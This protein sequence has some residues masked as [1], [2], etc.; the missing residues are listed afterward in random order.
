MCL[1]FGV[2]LV[3]HQLATNENSSGGFLSKAI[4]ELSQLFQP[5][6]TRLSQT[7]TNALRECHTVEMWRRLNKGQL[8]ISLT[9]VEYF[10]RPMR[11]AISANSRKENPFDL[12]HEGVL[13]L[14]NYKTFPNPLTR[15]ERDRWSFK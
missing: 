14:P 13:L 5:D 6:L 9:L 1:L 10:A 2:C 3:T 12:C 8:F 4:P 15:F 7:F 11:D